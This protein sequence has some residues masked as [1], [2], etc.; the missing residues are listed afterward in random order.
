MRNKFIYKEE[1][2]VSTINVTTDPHQMWKP[3]VLQS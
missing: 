3:Y 2:G 1:N